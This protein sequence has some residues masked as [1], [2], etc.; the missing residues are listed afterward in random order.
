MAFNPIEIVQ[1]VHDQFDELLDFVIMDAQ[2]ITANQVERH[3][4][5][6]L[7]QIGLLLLKAFF[8]VRCQTY[9]RDPIV[10][11]ESIKIP[12]LDDRERTYFSIFGKLKIARPYFY[13]R[14]VG[15]RSPLDTALGLG[16]DS[17]SDLLREMHEQLSVYLPY[18]KAVAI[19]SRF[20][21]IELSKRVTQNMVTED[22]VAV[23]AY[24][25]Q[26]E[27]PPP[28]QEAEILVIQGD[29]KGVPLVM[30][31]SAG[32]KTRLGKGEKRSRKKEAVVTSVY[33]IAA[34]PRTAEQVVNSLFKSKHTASESTKQANRPQNKQVWATLQGKDTAFDR[35]QVQVSKRE[36]NH[37]QHH[38]ALCDGD[39]ALQSRIEK[40][41]DRFCL[42]LDFIHANE[43]LWKVANSLLGEANAVRDTWVQKYSLL[44]LS[45][46]TQTIIDDFRH[47]VQTGELTTKQSEILTKTANYFERN[48][49]YMD[50]ATY[51]EK[52]WPI[53]SGVIEGA[54]R[55]LVKDRMELSGM[56]WQLDSAEALLNL[57]AV[58][59]N[60]D[61]DAYHT[62]RRRRRQQRLY[63]N[64]GSSP[65]AVEYDRLPCA[66]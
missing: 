38:V 4:F 2:E 66:A 56:R 33:T 36:G 34:R 22:A 23:A 30:Q 6:Q 12:Y 9:S 51:L 43:Y 13:R 7:L 29:G 35:L 37:I 27:P 48:L 53:A 40:R 10:E 61:W 3:I 44:M 62:F 15:G 45:S 57:R 65:E 14:P 11:A 31:T 17:Y 54:C 52:G 47:Q 60:D 5:R 63:G 39:E 46:Q 41:F 42:I 18:E 8:Q 20:L 19:M 28:A 50:Y 32:D 26:K 49:P 16:E 1:E 25:E 59:E 64:Q 55:H 24:Y 58:A 21:D